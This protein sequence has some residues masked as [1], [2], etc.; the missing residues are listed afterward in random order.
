MSKR[1]FLFDLE[2]AEVLKEYRPEVRHEVYDAIIEY[3]ASGTLN[4]E[5]K[6]LAAMAFSFIKRQMD[7]NRERYE[8][9]IEKKREGGRRSAAARQGKPDKA[10]VATDDTD[11]SRESSTDLSTLQDSSTDLNTPQHSSADSTDNEYE[12][13]NV[14][15]NNKYFTLPLGVGGEQEILVRKA[16]MDVFF[17][18]KTSER[19]LNK[20]LK[21]NNLTRESLRDMCEVILDEWTLFNKQHYSPEDARQHLVSAI[22]DRC[23]TTNGN[24]KPKRPAKKSEGTAAPKGPETT[25]ETLDRLD[26][27]Q[28]ERDEEFERRKENAVNPREYIRSLGYDPKRVSMMQVMNPDWRAKNPPTLPPEPSGS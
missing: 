12:Y 11:S 28:K 19:A 20:F 22:K 21:Q 8:S 13:D 18:P 25:E 10:E 15:D 5:L 2:W 7:Y 27:Q 26:R 24:K 1:S 6:P 4:A 16:Y 17:G 14:N 3:A 23:G 9:E